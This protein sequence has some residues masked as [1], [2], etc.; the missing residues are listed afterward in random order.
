MTPQRHILVKGCGKAGAQTSSLANGDSQSPP[1]K[2]ESMSD[3][4][5]DGHPV[6]KKE[7]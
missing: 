3:G 2:G 1:D 4:T 7:L 5:D 6:T